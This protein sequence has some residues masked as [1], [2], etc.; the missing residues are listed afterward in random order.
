M[1]QDFTAAELNEARR[2]IRTALKEDIRTG[3]ITTAATISPRSKSHAVIIAKSPGVLAGTVFCGRVYTEVSAAVALHFPVEDGTA[4]EPGAVVL[5]IRGPSAA[6]LKA[7]RT[8]LNLLARMSGIATMTRHIVDRL[9]GTKA[10]LLDT[11]KTM[12][13]LRLFDK[14]AVRAGGGTNHRY[15]L[16]DMFLV[17]ENHI[18]AAGGITEAIERCQS[19]RKSRGL[20]ARIVVE[21]AT[22]D[23]ARR[24]LQCGADRILLDNM[25]PAQVG[26]AVKEL[27]G[28]IDLEVSG[29]ITLEN[30]REYAETG[31]DYISTGVL[32]HSVK[33][34]DFSLLIT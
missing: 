34:M 2:I 32:T 23:E 1:T 16:D 13:G 10:V 21:A 30:I 17:K 11:R 18:S 25:S 29:G 22:M 19:Y 8:S 4:V 5:E 31:V 6:I 3:D 27:G 33:A 24:A 14:Y 7:E 9:R 20:E 28:K 26:E 12:P 15:A